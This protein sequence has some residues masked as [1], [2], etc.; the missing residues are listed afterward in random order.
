MIL[1]FEFI[2][3]LG[4]QVKDIGIIPFIYYE[5]FIKK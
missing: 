1:T 2:R 5:C 3:M 4:K